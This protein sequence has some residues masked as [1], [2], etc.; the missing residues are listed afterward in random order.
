[1]KSFI[2]SVLIFISIN[3]YADIPNSINICA[4]Y[5]SGIACTGHQYILNTQMRGTITQHEGI[6]FAGPPGTPI[7]SASHGVVLLTT[8]DHCGG[9]SITVAT[10][11]E[12]VNPETNEKE[13]LYVRYVHVVPNIENKNVKPGDL[14]GYI[15]DV[16]KIQSCVGPISHLHFETVFSYLPNKVHVN[17]HKYWAKGENNFTCFKNGMDVPVDKLVSPIKC[18]N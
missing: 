13:T 14:I 6:D 1:M 17:P 11:I 9:G 3:I 16:S 8:T 2:F 4:D 10:D 7:Y 15:Q 18:E 12:D 5:G